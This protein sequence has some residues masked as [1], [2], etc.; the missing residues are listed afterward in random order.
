[1]SFEKQDN[2]IGINFDLQKEKSNEKSKC[3][4]NALIY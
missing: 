2:F 3:N 1:M 4:Y